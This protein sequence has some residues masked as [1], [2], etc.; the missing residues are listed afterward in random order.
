MHEKRSAA[1]LSK[2]FSWIYGGRDS[3]VG[4]G[5]RRGYRNE[6]KSRQRGQKREGI[7][8]R[9]GEGQ[10]EEEKGENGK[11]EHVK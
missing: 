10:M 6:R 7:W 2:L 8:E 9:N 5:D 1:G 11:G 4:R 3:R